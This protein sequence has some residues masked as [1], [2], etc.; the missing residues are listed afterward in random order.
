MIVIDCEL[1][2]SVDAQFAVVD[3]I[4]VSLLREA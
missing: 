1:G 4:I 2:I 3:L